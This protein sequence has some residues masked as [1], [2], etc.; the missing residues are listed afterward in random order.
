[1]GR[2]IT[3][4]ETGAVQRTGRNPVAARCSSTVPL[5]ISRE[6]RR[7]PDDQEP[8]KKGLYL[9]ADTLVLTVSVSV[10]RVAFVLV[11]AVGLVTA[12]GGAV[13][14]DASEHD[15]DNETVHHQ[16]PD[17]IGQDGDLGAVQRWLD[18]EMIEI[19]LDCAENLSLGEAVACERLDEDYPEYLS[20]YGSVEQ[21]LSGDTETR[22]TYE[23]TRE[24]QTD[25]VEA[26]DEFNETYEEYQAARE[27]GDEERAR[28]LAREL[29]VLA[30]R[31]D[32]RGGN[33]DVLFRRLE[34][35]TSQDTDTA[36]EST[37]ETVIRV[38][39]IIET[40]E[41]ET[42]TPTELSATGAGSPI[43]FPCRANVSTSLMIR[44]MRSCAVS[45]FA[46]CSSTPV[47]RATSR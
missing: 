29:Q 22:D 6:V 8:G 37:N 44:S 7:E 39:N 11:V 17:E 27:A 15:A 40:V 16:N 18:R 23:Q 33:L 34:E 3:P 4:I 32:E 14:V 13:V 5:E 24:N 12:A 25:L 19:H 31:I 35:T 2:I 46:K 20:Q 47:S 41:E 43:D 28:E 45:T 26:L 21:D 1:V 42:F 9:G 30:Q 38:E 10:S 36:R